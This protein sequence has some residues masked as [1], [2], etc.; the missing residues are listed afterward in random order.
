MPFMKSCSGTRV[1]VAVGLGGSGVAVR[2]GAGVA[3]AGAVAV[4]VGMAGA[5]VP[6]A[7]RSRLASRSVRKSWDRVFCM[8]YL[9]GAVLTVWIGCA[10]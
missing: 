3:V 6:Q 9:S 8:G 1:G 2:V 5:S 7:L 4:C 10:Q